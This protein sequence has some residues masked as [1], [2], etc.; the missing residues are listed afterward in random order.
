MSEVVCEGAPPIRDA[1][2]VPKSILDLLV[3]R[4]QQT[5]QTPEFNQQL[6][7]FLTQR[8]SNE[9]LASLVKSGEELLRRP[10]N[11]RWRVRSNPRIK[12]LARLKML[13]LLDPGLRVEAADELEKAAFQEHDLSFMD[14]D[15]LL[16]LIE[17][18][19]LLLLGR[20]LAAL[21]DADIPNRII[22]IEQQADPD[23]CVPDEFDEPRNFVE[24][25][26]EIFGEDDW[27]TDRLDELDEQIDQAIEDV[28][29]R[30]IDDDDEV[31]FWSD[32]KPAVV[33]KAEG[34]RSI[35]SDVDD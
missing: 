23:S 16:E 7:E 33:T 14:D 28:K 27:I 18:T 34:T 32:V 10:L 24:K 1:V 13:G 8:A 15:G 4:L 3:N 19:K 5:P 29:G 26:R 25:L 30:K 35:F 12:L 2:V 21:L 6:F 20:R 9:I 11:T 17:P 22:E 31:S